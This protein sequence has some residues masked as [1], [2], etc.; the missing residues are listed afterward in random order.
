LRTLDAD[1]VAVAERRWMVATSF[2]RR[3]E[4]LADTFATIHRLLAEREDPA[5]WRRS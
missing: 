1:S 2:G 3:C 5:D 4:V